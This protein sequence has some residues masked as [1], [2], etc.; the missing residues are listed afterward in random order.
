MS[1]RPRDKRDT[2]HQHAP[3]GRGRPPGARP[4]PSGRELAGGA[5][6]PNFVDPNETI[7]ALMDVFAGQHRLDKVIERRLRANRG[8]TP[9]VR[10]KFVETLHEVVRQWRLR[11]SRADLPEGD[12]LLRVNFARA[13][14]VLEARPRPEEREHAWSE[15]IRASMPDWL[16]QRGTAELGKRWPGLVAA[17][18]QPAPMFLRVNLLRTEPAALVEALL[19]EGI[20]ATPVP[21]QPE[22]LLLSARRDVF[23][24]QPFRD[25]WFEVQDLHSQRVAPFLQVEPGQRVID[26]CAG[27]GGKSLH[28]AALMRNK[29]KIIALDTAEWKL[30]ELRRRAARAG[31]DNLEAR[32][33]NETPKPGE[34]ARP[35]R[36][37]VVP[38][39]L[40]RLLGTADRVLVDVPCSGVGVLRRNPDARWKL[41]EDELDRLRELQAQLLRD[42]SG[43]AKPGGKLVYATCSVLPSENERQVRDFLAAQPGW[44]LE[45]EL[46]LDPGVDGGDGFYAARLGRAKE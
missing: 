45:E 33:L 44:S 15:A 25:G 13:K 35:P 38:R 4:R 17:L 12:Y 21:G 34:A 11:W 39:E 37:G 27:S 26:A 6:G 46:R 2:G 10:G 19:A 18:N 22:A 5:S 43:L 32:N 16:F 20:R 28:L 8:W 3:E 29:G 14:E 30:T 40:K 7:G 41:G 31:V 24:S 42:Y 23:R 36:P 1:K 9:I